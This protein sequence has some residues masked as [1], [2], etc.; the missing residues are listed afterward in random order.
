MYATSP[1]RVAGVVDTPI[2]GAGTEGADYTERLQRLGGASWKRVLDVQAPYRWNIRR[3]KL[4]HTL[5]VGCGIG[6]NLSHLG[7]NGV[8]V[9]HN[10]ASIE[11]CR[12]MGLRAYTIEDFL[13]SEYA[14]R[15]AFDSLLAAHLLEHLAEPD[16]RAIVESY[17]PY[18]RTGGT[19][20]FITP[21]ERGY[22]SDA[23]HVRFVDFPEAAANA[24]AMG[25]EVTRQYSF[26]FPRV[27]G[28]AFTYN[29]FVTIARK[30]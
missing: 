7:G 13:A 19:I 29:E 14:R 26:P 20:V 25:L 15:D 11:A 10:P 3:L 16:A 8:G 9:D 4:G 30:V 5:D 21:Q 2:P 27:A 18:V 6:R 17:L 1:G 23:T 22:A 24:R 28:K 12:A